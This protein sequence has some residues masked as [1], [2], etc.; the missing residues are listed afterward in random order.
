MR[1]FTRRKPEDRTLTRGDVPAVML[2]STPSGA[3]VNPTT[4]LTIADAYAC[5]RALSDAA[6]SLP[7]ITY[8][9]TETGRE[10]IDNHTAQLLRAP[11][12]AVTQANLVG[13]M[14]AHLNLHGNCFTAKYRDADGRIEQLG[15][16]PPDRVTVELKGGMPLYT[17][18]D[19]R[20]RESTH[21]TSDIIHIKALSTDGLVG[22]SPVRQCRAA[23]GLSSSLTE[24]A[25]TFFER[26]GLPP[27]I[28]S[29]P[30]S[31]EA[32]RQLA[33]QWNMGRRRETGWHRV[34]VMS[35]D[36]TFTP[37]SMPMEDQQ[38]LQQRELSATEVARLFR[39][40]PWVIGAPDG[41]SL[42]YSN[43]QQQAEAFLKFSLQPWLTIIEQALSAD[44]DLFN[45]VT[46]CE[47]LVDAMLRSDSATRADVYTKALD[48][49]TGWMT[50]Q[51]VRRL[52]NLDPER[53]A[54]DGG[55]SGAGRIGATDGSAGA[56]T[57]HR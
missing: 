12:P 45:R 56:R 20:G 30:G 57:A 50:R 22:L 27:A 47:F 4:A 8:R 11:A 19:E 43:V 37:V 40:P 13:Q 48:P 23:L 29:V 32:V 26:G 10:R 2:S 31:N 25:S 15:L 54:T 51:E 33:D 9:R 42:T 14:V 24:H 28:L 5:I 16:L 41:G 53:E 3:T 49:V 36:V 44:T 55:P 38:F 39:V 1:L 21:T 6:A 18:R 46:Y 34:A 52:E 7:L 17:L 35:G